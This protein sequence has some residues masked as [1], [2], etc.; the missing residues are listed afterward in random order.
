[1]QSEIQGISPIMQSDKVI[2]T[3]QAEITALRQEVAALK[4]VVAGQAAKPKSKPKP[5]PKHQVKRGKS[6]KTPESAPAH[7]STKIKVVGQQIS[8]S[9]PKIQS[10]S[11]R[12][13]KGVLGAGLHS[14]SR[15]S[16]ET[17]VAS[18]K[19]IFRAERVD[20]S[21][22]KNP[23]LISERKKFQKP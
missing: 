14:G 10:Q 8:K 12:F 18:G 9:A 5:Q 11:S 13:S 7:D 17:K 1:M 21:R 22:A 16:T 15:A 4:E 6:S 2:S 19:K 23:I 20:Y 3:M